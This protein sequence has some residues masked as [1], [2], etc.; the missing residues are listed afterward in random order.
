[1]LAGKC[2]GSVVPLKIYKELDPEGKDTK[3]LYV[4]KAAPGQAFTASKRIPPEIRAKIADALMSAEGQ[5]VTAKLRQRYPSQPYI[6]ATKKEYSGEDDLLK[7]SFGFD[8]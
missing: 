3:V 8:S 1:M 4:T 2:I 7:D 6:R 5:A